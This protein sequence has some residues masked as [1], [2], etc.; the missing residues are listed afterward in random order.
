[1]NNIFEQLSK[2]L[3][4]RYF[5]SAQIKKEIDFLS[6]HICELS[7]DQEELFENFELDI[8]ESIINNSKLKLESED[9]LLRII[10]FLY[11]KEKKYSPLYEY[12]DF[13]HVD[14]NMMKEFGK[15]IEIDDINCGTWKQLLARMTLEVKINDIETSQRKKNKNDKS[16]V[17]ERDKQRIEI[18]F[19]GSPFA[20]IFNKLKEISNI[21]EEA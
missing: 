8:I 14:K 13:I 2:H 11:K 10:N 16:D 4:Q 7:H 20:G 21:E 3:H 9:Q 18:P 19:N 12:V 6:S 17:K 15:I 5:Y 1:M